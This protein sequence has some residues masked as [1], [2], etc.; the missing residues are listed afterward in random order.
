MNYCA[1]GKVIYL[2]ISDYFEVKRIDL[3][4]C[5][6]QNAKNFGEKEIEIP[7]QVRKELEELGGFETLA[8]RIPA[9]GDLE[10]AG[11]I[12]RFPTRCGLR[13]STS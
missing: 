8:K 7:E 3:S 5:G 12:T 11:F 10:R 2:G 6:T 1:Q 9:S 13:S 4:C